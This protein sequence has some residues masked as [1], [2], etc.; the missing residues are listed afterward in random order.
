MGIEDELLGKKEEGQVSEKF[1]KA[2]Q[3]LIPA[4]S[5][6]LDIDLIELESYII[7]TVSDREIFEEIRNMPHHWMVANLVN[8]ATSG[9]FTPFAEIYDDLSEDQISQIGEAYDSIKKFEEDVFGEYYPMQSGTAEDFEM[10][11]ERMRAVAV[12]FKTLGIEKPVD[13]IE[14]IFFEHLADH[15]FLHG[16]KLPPQLTMIL[17]KKSLGRIKRI[18]EIADAADD[19]EDWKK[20]KARLEAEDEKKRKEIMSNGTHPRVAE[21][22]IKTENESANQFFG[23]LVRRMENETPIEGDFLRGLL[24]KHPDPRVLIRK[25]VGREDDIPQKRE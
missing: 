22:I 5:S 4:L 1:I 14:D 8:G 23:E 12:V 3:E 11:V 9:L 15:F 2:R 21:R 19:E 6:V 25:I 20:L 18:K 24:E 17:S 7:K 10:A 16:N 13:W